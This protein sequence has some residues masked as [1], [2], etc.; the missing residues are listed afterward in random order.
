MY[1]SLD[2]MIQVLLFIFTNSYGD[3]KK[4]RKW[5]IQGKIFNIIIF[6]YLIFIKLILFLYL[7][8][9]LS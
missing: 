5:K 6:Y 3:Q 8:I 7:L 1:F 4:E 2:T 9:L